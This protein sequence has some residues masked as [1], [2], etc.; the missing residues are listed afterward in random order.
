MTTG[1]P[2]AYEPRHQPS[3]RR[4][5]P[6][7]GGVSPLT[8][9]GSETH[10]RVAPPDLRNLGSRS[11]AQAYGDCGTSTKFSNSEASLDAADENL[12]ER[13]GRVSPDFRERPLRHVPDFSAICDLFHRF[14]RHNLPCTVPNRGRMDSRQ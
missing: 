6:P 8:Q 9:E 3:L 12:P 11:S 14:I 13:E 4:R 7:E 5:P 10:I 1:G 2:L